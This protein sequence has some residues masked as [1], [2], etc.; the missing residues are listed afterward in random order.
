MIRLIS[1]GVL[2]IAAL[3]TWRLVSPA[4]VNQQFANQI[5][6]T[7]TASPDNPAIETRNIGFDAEVPTGAPTEAG[8]R[9]R[10]GGLNTGIPAPNPANPSPFP[11]VAPSPA[12]QS[13]PVTGV[14]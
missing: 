11:E 6:R 3:L 2:F 8:D 7:E 13:A 4:L 14:W 10:A 9:T 1:A 12:P 5:F